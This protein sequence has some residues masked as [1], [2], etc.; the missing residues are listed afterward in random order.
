MP[1]SSAVW[2]NMDTLLLCCLFGWDLLLDLRYKILT[3]FLYFWKYCFILQFFFLIYFCLLTALV[4]MAKQFNSSFIRPKCMILYVFP[5]WKL[6][7]TNNLTIFQMITI[8]FS[9]WFMI[10][11]SLLLLIWGAHFYTKESSFLGNPCLRIPALVVHI[12]ADN[13][14][15]K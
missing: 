2:K 10:H 12:K 8:L 11:F 13:P 9:L 1:L 5:T 4:I 6:F 3:H 15:A 7:W 14:F